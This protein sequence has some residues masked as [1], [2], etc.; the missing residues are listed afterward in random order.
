VAWSWLFAL[1]W[2]ADAL[3]PVEATVELAYHGWRVVSLADG[4]RCSYLPTCSAFAARALR[5]DGLLGLPLVFDRL[6]REP[7]AQS[8]PLAPDRRHH[9]DPLGAHVRVVDLVRGCRRERRAGA[10]ACLR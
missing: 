3:D 7:I 4:A 2:A 5:R 9:A 10:G 6:A 8:Y 1:A